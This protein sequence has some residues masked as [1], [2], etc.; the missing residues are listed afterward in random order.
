MCSIRHGSPA[1]LQRPTR[2]HLA[3]KS[4]RRSPCPHKT[5]AHGARLANLLA[6]ELPRIRMAR[7]QSSA[8]ATL[9]VERA[10]LVKVDDWTAAFVPPTGTTD[11]NLVARFFLHGHGYWPVCGSIGF[12][13][14]AMTRRG[15][16]RAMVCFSAQLAEQREQWFASNHCTPCHGHRAI[17]VPDGR[18]HGP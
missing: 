10:D 2:D 12:G 11:C 3:T 6:L 1:C 17:C 18:L 13:S 9:F 14:I 5:R 8:A 16:W 15:G 4:I 7:Q